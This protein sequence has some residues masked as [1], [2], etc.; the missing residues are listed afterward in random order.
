MAP[1]FWLVTNK[2]TCMCV[3]FDE[4]KVFSLYTKLNIT[5]INLEHIFHVYCIVSTQNVS[6]TWPDT[7][8]VFIWG[9][10]KSLVMRFCKA[11]KTFYIKSFKHFTS[12]CALR[13]STVLAVKRDNRY[14]VDSHGGHN[15]FLNP[16]FLVLRKAKPEANIGTKSPLIYCG[17]KWKSAKCRKML[18]KMSDVFL[19]ILLVLYTC[20]IS[21]GFKPNFFFTC[22]VLFESLV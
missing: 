4:N 13:A 1:K 5:Q 11:R 9:G 8:R 6:A 12:K 20:S 14:M 22:R 16:W 2:I 17:P 19:F 7:T 15:R 21:E 10:E 18:R 3:C